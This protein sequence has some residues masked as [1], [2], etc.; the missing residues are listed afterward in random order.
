MSHYLHVSVSNFQF[1][2]GTES[3]VAVI[4]AGGEDQ[5]DGEDQVNWQDRQI[6]VSSVFSV[7][8]DE[9]CARKTLV[10]FGD[11]L[12]DMQAFAL[13]VDRVFGTRDIKDKALSAVPPF[14]P[15]FGRLVDGAYL[16]PDQA[17]GGCLLRLRN[18][19]QTLSPL[20][21]DAA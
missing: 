12:E 5:R 4:D 13:P 3:I 7:L 16:D 1:L 17:R 21:E 14:N 2:I 19:K 9:P 20:N 15:E 11:G 10:V 6:P 8:P 18:P